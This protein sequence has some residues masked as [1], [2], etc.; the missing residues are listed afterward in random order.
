MPDL[1]DATAIL[2]RRRA[3][4]FPLMVHLGQAYEGDGPAWIADVT[5]TLDAV[6]ALVACVEVLEDERDAYL[7]AAGQQLD[8]NTPLLERIKELEQQ[9]ADSA[10]A[11]D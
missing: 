1:I 7:A 9:L 6:P 11:A 8:I 4:L 10:A 5:A 2:D 3:G